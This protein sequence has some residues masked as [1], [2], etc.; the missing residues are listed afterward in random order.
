MPDLNAVAQVVKK[1]WGYDS[2]LPLQAEAMTAALSK[3]DSVVVMPTGGG[4]SLCFQAPAVLC[5]GLTV[6]VSPLISLMKDQVD[7]LIDCGVSAG[8]LDSSQTPEERSETLKHLSDK[9]LK[10]LY[11]SPERLLGAGG[12]ELLRESKIEAIIL[13]EAHCVSMW[14]HDFRPEYRRLG[15]LKDIFPNTP[16]H[17]YTATATEK[18][19]DD[20]AEQL[21]LVSPTMLVGNFD[22]PNLVYSVERKHKMLEQ[23][24]ETLNKH[25]GESGIIY[26][27][28]RRDVQDMCDYLNSDG[29]SAAPYHAGLE[30]ELRKANQEAF[31]NEDVDVIV[32]TVAFGMGIDKSNVR[33]VIHAGMPKSI[34]HYQ[35]ESGRAGRDRLEADCVLLYSGGDYGTWNRIMQGSEQEGLDISL[36]KL[37][38]IYDF[39]TGVTCRHKALVNY[40]G[41]E[42]APENCG[43]CDICLGNLDT[44]DGALVIAQKI[45]SCVLRLD[46]RFGA[47]YTTQVLVG[48]REKRILEFGHDTLSTFSI[49]DEFPVRAVR[50][51]VEQLVA[52]GYLAKTGEFNVLAVSESGRVVLRGDA[53]PK[54]LKPAEKSSKSKGPKT[55]KQ[56]SE[57]WEGVDK[58]LFDELRTLRKTIAQR[59]GAP[60][61]VVFHDTSLRDM[62]RKKPLDRSSF[63]EMYG[64]GESKAQKYADEFLPLIRDY[65]G[66]KQN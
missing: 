2:F 41:Q 37:N 61:Y 17:A 52:Q 64:V 1:H 58:D 50:D 29:Y 60:P 40:F 5:E 7:A 56:I 20:I 4:K 13:D 38:E 43:A 48:S 62:A 26:C 47:A 42:F 49:L 23:V 65:V 16:I 10:L 44:V 3:A 15:G 34:E 6:V 53:T 11:L 19:R 9:T 59:T 33:F 36:R 32:A 57:N 25:R 51:W 31:I 39:C 30:P 24:I 12:V 22:R 14:G 8:R 55:S 45:I 27:I 28:R 46:Q 21:Q 18:V 66:Q 63:L 35:Q 54:L